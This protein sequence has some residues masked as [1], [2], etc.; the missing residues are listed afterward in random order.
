MK[1]SPAPSTCCMQMTEPQHRKK[2]LKNNDYKSKT[3]K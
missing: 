3:V 1:L 2:W